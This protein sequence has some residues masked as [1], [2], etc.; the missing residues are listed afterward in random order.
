ME[1]SDFGKGESILLEY[2]QSAFNRVL[3]Y[4]V[5]IVFI[6]GIVMAVRKLAEDGGK[7][8]AETIF[9]IVWCTVMIYIVWQILYRQVIDIKCTN[10]GIEVATTYRHEMILWSELRILCHQRM[11]SYV[12]LAAGNHPKFFL[13]SV[14][15][16]VL[17][18]LEAMTKEC[19]NARVTDGWL[20]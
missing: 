8:I 4:V 2:R 19:S 13:Y 17:D 18:K 5:S 11:G 12:S 10:S 7:D 20:L 9:L 14:P 3:Y 15:K 6:V 1:N 16:D